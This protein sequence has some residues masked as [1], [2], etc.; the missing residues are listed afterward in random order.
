MKDM[1]IVNV[2]DTI[3]NTEIKESPVHGMGLFSISG[4]KKGTVLTELDGQ[5]ISWSQYEE[6]SKSFANK[7]LENT[8][9]MEWNAITTDLLLVRPFRT[10][11]SFINHTR[12]PNVKV[13]QNPLRV[14]A[15]SDIN[16]G[17]EILLDY[18]EEPLSEDY[19]KGHGSTYL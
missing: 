13:L 19:L 12:L 17:D 1:L 10:K 9:F 6:I 5:Y 3:K 7:G 2:V 18:R 11:Y 15:I 14:V 8:F 16:A 4:I